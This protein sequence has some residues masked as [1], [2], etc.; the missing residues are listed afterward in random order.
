MYFTTMDEGVFLTTA[1]RSEGPW[2]QARRVADLKNHDDPC[3]FWDD[4]GKAYLLLSTPGSEW[5]THIYHMAP[6]GYSIDL[7]SE[8]VL[9][10]FPTSEGNKL[11][12]IDGTYFVFHNEVRNGHR[13]GVMMRSRSLEGRGKRRRSWKT[14]PVKWNWNP[15]RAASCKR[16]RVTGGLS[17]NKEKA[18]G[19]A[20]HPASCPCAGSTAGRSPARRT[21]PARATS[22]GTP[23]NPSKDFPPPGRTVQR[24]VRLTRARPA[25]GVEHQPRADKWS[26]GERPGWLRLHAFKPLERGNFFK[27][28]N[29]LS[30]RLIGYS[31]GTVEVKLDADG[32]ADGQIAGLVFY[33]RNYAQVGVAQREGKRRIICNDNGT[34]SEGPELPPG[35]VVWV[36]ALID[37]QAGCTF[38]YSFD[39][40]SFMPIGQRFP[41]GWHNYRDTRLGLFTYNDVGENGHV[42]FDYLHYRYHGPGPL[43]AQKEET[44]H[45]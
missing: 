17:R 9:D 23:K 1:E 33:W 36:R 10:G 32:M 45:R 24:R 22:R 37:D 29:T 3:P 34:V 43:P 13:V 44:L 20:G 18:R 7:Q 12:K 31:G 11:Y 8:R 4:D 28:G 16:R 40:R 41:F 26:L 15:T 6:D 39:G 35:D 25:M 30:E 19:K 14:L 27:A 5:F 21:R 38:G 42:D 2:S